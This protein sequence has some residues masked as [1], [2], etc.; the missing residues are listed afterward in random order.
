MDCG[1][2]IKSNR[3]KQKLQKTKLSMKLNV[4]REAVSNWGELTKVFQI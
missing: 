1:I 2:Q 3:Q 4:S